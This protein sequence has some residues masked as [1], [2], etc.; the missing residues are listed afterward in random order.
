MPIRKS[1]PATDLTGCSYLVWGAVKTG[2]TTFA[3]RFPG[4]VFLAC[5]D[6]M[7]GVQADRWEGD[8]GHY[9]LRSWE[10][11]TQATTEVL[12]L[13]PRPSMIAI[14]TIDNA[15][16]L[17]EQHIC[18]RYSVEYKNDDALAFGKGAALINAELRR[19][20]LKLS[21]IGVGIILT[22]HTAPAERDTK[23]GHL[24]VDHPS[25][26]DKVMP[27]ILGMMDFI[28]FCTTDTF[29]KSADAEPET[30]HIMYTR[31]APTHIAGHR[32]GRL[33]EVLPLSYFEFVKAFAKGAGAVRE[34]DG[35]TAAPV[36]TAM[37]T[38]TSDAT[39]MAAPSP[40]VAPMD[41]QPA[42]ASTEAAARPAAAPRTKRQTSDR[43]DDAAQ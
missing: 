7:K 20:L 4:V 19:Y 16:F 31:P 22:S 3:S 42:P 40:T 28:F 39:A 38:T 23:K 24:T 32:I 25:I 41:S 12:A 1:I 9:V 36:V 10:E 35:T 11:L 21:S 13:S 2:K 29:K 17:L 26:P 34:S 15:Y 27:M 18:R 5:E 37:S 14:D 30:R 6:G 43:P 8:D 33:P